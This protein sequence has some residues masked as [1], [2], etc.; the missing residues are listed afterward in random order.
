MKKMYKRTTAIAASALMLAQLVPYNVFAETDTTEPINL[1]IHPYIL[2][3]AKYK[4]AEKADYITQGKKAVDEPMAQSYEGG[5][6]DTSITFD[7]VEVNTD[8]SVKEGGHHEEGKTEFTNLPNAYYK[9]IPNRE[10][11]T[12]ARFK[13]AE[14]FYIHL[15]TVVSGQALFDVDIYPK[16]TENN[17]TTND[18]N[19]PEIET[20]PATDPKTT[21]NK[22]SLKLQKKL[23]GSDTWDTS[24]NA[25]FKIYYQNT[26][27]KWVEVGDFDTDDNGIIQVDG[28]PLGTYYA[29]ETDA[30]E[31]YLLDQTPIKF[32]LDG[33]GVISKQFKTFT[34]DKELKV[35]KEVI[36]SGPETGLQYKWKIT[37]DVPEKTEN[38]LS[39]TITDKYTNL[40]I[41]NISIN[42]FT[43]D[44]DYTVTN[45]TA[46]GTVTIAFTADGIAKLS[47]SSIEIIVTSNNASSGDVANSAAIAYKYAFNP[48]DD[49]PNTPD[50]DIYIVIPEPS[51]TYPTPIS[52]PDPSKPDPDDDKATDEFTPATITISNVDANNHDKELENGKYEVSRCSPYDD[53][54]TTKLVTLENLAPGVY[55][56]K[57]LATES[58]YYVEDDVNKNT[59]TIFIDK[60]GKVYEGTDNTGTELTDKK[61]IFYNDATVSGFDLPFTGTTATI[62]FTIAGIGVMGG[63]MFLFFI[64]FKKR[65]KDEEDKENA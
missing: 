3:E 41:T 61:V 34:N 40:N 14:S 65:D 11:H 50:D 37:A 55:T 17:D 45:D 35:A 27:D 8:G 56:I 21:P 30:P 38:L 2:S 39:Y 62:V 42:G 46:T 53:D 54:A 13:D 29:I 9:L 51:D 57:Q 12:D 58:G 33:T 28:L 26:L 19:D 47:G 63:A 60:N 6:E 18:S 5:Y 20:D 25:T 31:G 15:P 22:H 44:S 64:L 1:R 16:L 4:E 59:K 43:V 48:P 32:E 49:D 23:R 7:I 10:G 24:L 36:T 52:Y